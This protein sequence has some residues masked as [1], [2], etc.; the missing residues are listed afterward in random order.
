MSVTDDERNQAVA[1]LTTLRDG[2]S[3]TFTDEWI[4]EHPG[5][6]LLVSY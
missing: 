5:A 4:D 2:Q 6:V 3:Q 1:R